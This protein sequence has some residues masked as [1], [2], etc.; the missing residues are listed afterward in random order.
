[1]G[2]AYLVFLCN[3][4]WFRHTSI[5][6]SITDDYLEEQNVDMGDIEQKE[7]ELKKTKNRK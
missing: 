5:V 1:M 6:Q 2:L 3:Q 7:P 4:D